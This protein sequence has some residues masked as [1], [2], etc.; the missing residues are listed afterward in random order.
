MS[1]RGIVIPRFWSVEKLHSKVPGGAGAE[2]EERR[3]YQ[4][5]PAPGRDSSRPNC[6]SRQACIPREAWRQR[7]LIASLCSCP[8][9]HPAYSAK[10]LKRYTSASVLLVYSTVFGWRWSEGGCAS[11]SGDRRPGQDNHSDGEDCTDS[12]NNWGKSCIETW[13]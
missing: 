12:R 9:D 5:P 3:A 11:N 13:R 8:V 2:V 10:L 1:T 4:T 7:V 6:Y